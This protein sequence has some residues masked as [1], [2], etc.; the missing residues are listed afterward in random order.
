MLIQALR[1]RDGYTQGELAYK[2]GVCKGTVAMWEVGTRYPSLKMK[3]KLANCFNVPLTHFEV[4]EKETETMVQDVTQLN[5]E[6]LIVTLAMSF[7]KNKG[8]RD[9]LKM[10]ISQI[11]MEEEEDGNKI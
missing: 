1:K 2:L 7:M 10:F 8:T 5:P 6:I 4:G 3:I 11:E 9:A